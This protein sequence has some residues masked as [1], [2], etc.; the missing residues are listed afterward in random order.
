M[1]ALDAPFA[2]LPRVSFAA[3]GPTDAHRARLPVDGGAR[4]AMRGVNLLAELEALVV[5]GAGR[6]E[7]GVHHALNVFRAAPLAEH[8]GTPVA[9]PFAERAD[10]RHWRARIYEEDAYLLARMASSPSIAL[11]HVVGA[12]WTHLAAP[13]RER[14]ARRLEELPEDGM[15]RAW[16]AAGG[17]PWWEPPASAGVQTHF[18]DAAATQ[19]ALGVHR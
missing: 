3:A 9:N 17:A 7:V 1:R 6:F 14:I 13:Y 4:A 16:K 18:V 19:H 15:A 5:L 8:S 11:S 12:T 2:P 10:R